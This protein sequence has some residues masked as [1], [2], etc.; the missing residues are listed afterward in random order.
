MDMDAAQKPQ[1]ARSLLAYAESLVA[2]GFALNLEHWAV[3]AGKGIDDLLAAGK[4][5]EVLTG[6]AALEKVVRSL[7]PPGLSQQNQN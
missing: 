3:D 7:G 1:V 6:E 5:P 4:L 2:E